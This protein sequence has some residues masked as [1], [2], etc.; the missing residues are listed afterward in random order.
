MYQINPMTGRLQTSRE[1]LG[2][3]PWY[4]EGPNCTGRS[5]YRFA[6]TDSLSPMVAVTLKLA[7]VIPSTYVFSRNVKLAYS[8]DRK[9]ASFPNKMGSYITQ[10]AKGL[11][12][13]I[14]SV[15]DWPATAINYNGNNLQLFYYVA[16]EDV[17]AVSDPN[18]INKPTVPP[19]RFV[20][21]L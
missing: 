16:Y 17:V 9:M 6:E 18:T 5:W 20:P 21:N 11:A 19:Y 2:F 15:Q 4:F 3:L 7:G 13:C 12:V 10:D 1:I 14:T 8:Y